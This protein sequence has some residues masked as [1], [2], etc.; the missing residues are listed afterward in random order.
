M[1]DRVI[2]KKK[3]PP[4]KILTIAGIA[5]LVLLASGSYYFTSWK[6]RLNQDLVRLTISTVTKRPFQET[7]PVNGTV[8]PIKSIYLDATEGGRVEEKYVEDGTFMKKGQ[9]IL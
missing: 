6:S 3:W 8:L 5:A 2:K 1:V 9:P 4:R 7:I